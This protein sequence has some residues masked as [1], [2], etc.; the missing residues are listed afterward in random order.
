MISVSLLD[1]RGQF[2]TPEQI[3]AAHAAINQQQ[4]AQIL[5][6]ACKLYGDSPLYQVATEGTPTA[7]GTRYK[8]YLMRDIFDKCAGQSATTEAQAVANL[9]RTVKTCLENGWDR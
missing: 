7:Q 8:A 2:R 9:L 6:L 4:V 3:D 5:A 1:E